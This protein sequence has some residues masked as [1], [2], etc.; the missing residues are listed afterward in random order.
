[1]EQYAYRCGNSL[2]ATLPSRACFTTAC[3]SCWGSLHRSSTPAQHHITVEQLAT[4]P[5]GREI[6][7]NAH[8]PVGLCSDAGQQ[9][10]HNV[11]PYS[12][13]WVPTNRYSKAA[14]LPVGLRLD[15]GQQLS[16]LPRLVQLAWVVE[17]GRGLRLAVRQAAKQDVHIV[18][19]SLMLCLL[20][21]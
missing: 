20:A 16:A 18:F 4:I 17:L 9:L 1:M 8:L 5:T 15:A 11:H 3:T 2:A 12:V 19:I 13:A 7:G 21:C 14:H 10:T 6:A